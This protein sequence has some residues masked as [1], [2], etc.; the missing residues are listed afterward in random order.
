MVVWLRV[1][2]YD[3]AL[4]QRHARSLVAVVLDR[5]TSGSEAKASLL[6]DSAVMEGTQGAP[7]H[8]CSVGEKG[9]REIE[10]EERG[11]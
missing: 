10:R 5:G 6:C 9:E 4:R 11:R 8:V 2:Y 3:S 1:G 7:I